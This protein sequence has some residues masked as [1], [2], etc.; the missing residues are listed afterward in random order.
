M[1]EFPKT[2][3]AD[4]YN[5]GFVAGWEHAMAVL[6]WFGMARP[7]ETALVKVKRGVPLPPKRVPDP[8]AARFTDNG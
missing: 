8:P 7:D 3:D 1:T 6:E 5:E 4:D 2:T